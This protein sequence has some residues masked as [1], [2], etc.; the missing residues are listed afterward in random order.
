MIKIFCFINILFFLLFCFVDFS[1]AAIEKGGKKSDID[2]LKAQEYNDIWNEENINNKSFIALSLK[3]RGK[4]LQIYVSPNGSLVLDFV[5]KNSRT[6]PIQRKK[7]IDNPE[8]NDF[9][10]LL[11]LINNAIKEYNRIE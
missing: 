11:S 10:G 4:F 7:I 1:Y 5:N 2:K 6:S 9:S 8:F 3:D